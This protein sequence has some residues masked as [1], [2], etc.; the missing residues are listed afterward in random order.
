MSESKDAILALMNDYC[1]RIDR[2]DLDGFAGL[3][4]RARFE[5]AGDPSGPKD[6]AAAV[7]EML[8]QVTLYEGQTL[9]RHVLSNVQI[10][11]DEAAGTASAQS[12]ITVYQA[13]PPD[14]PLQPIFMGHYFDRFA[15]DGQGW[16]V[17]HRL[18][19]NF[20]VGDLSRHRADMA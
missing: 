11:V 20:L 16:Y 1:Y 8:D 3:F 10:E 2:A 17:T 4:E 9:A 18:I 5:I 14:F 6:G 12:Y 19:D 15:R 13:V 7:R